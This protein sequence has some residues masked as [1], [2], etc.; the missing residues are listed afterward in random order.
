[1]KSQQYRL[2]Y[3]PRSKVYVVRVTYGLLDTALL[4][5]GKQYQSMKEA[6]AAAKHHAQETCVSPIILR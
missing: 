3:L 5:A 2:E 1:M 6:T 4:Y